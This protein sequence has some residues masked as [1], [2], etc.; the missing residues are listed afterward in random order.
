MQGVIAPFRKLA[1]D[2]DQALHVGHLAR[3][4]DVIP[5]HAQ[6]LGPGRVL[7]RRNH[8]RFPGH[9]GGILGI[10]QFRVV[11]HHPGDQFLIQAAPVDADAHRAAVFERRFDH[12]RELAFAFFPEADV[13]RVDPVFGQGLR[14]GGI[15]GQELVAVVVEI[16][17]QGHAAGP[18]VQRVTDQGNGLGRGLVVDRDPHQFRAGAGK[19]G[20]LFHR[21]F[22]VG[23]VGVGH[24]LDDDGRP[25]AHGDAAD[26]NGDAVSSWH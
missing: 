18:L 15:L 9:L 3:K 10:V 16:A 6:F 26:G 22:D 14:T 12:G 2:G 4:N 8:Q 19:P 11:V 13:A 21:S 23:G 20:H 17:D 24:R 1:V 7:Q 5:G 25:A